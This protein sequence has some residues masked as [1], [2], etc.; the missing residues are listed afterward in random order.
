M[1]S[2]TINNVKNNKS[3]NIFKYK[4]Y[5]NENIYNITVLKEN[6]IE[7][8]TIT[9]NWDYNMVL[10][11]IKITLNRNVITNNGKE[12]TIMYHYYT[13]IVYS[14]YAGIRNECKNTNH[15]FYNI[16]RDLSLQAINKGKMYT[17]NDYALKMYL[18]LYKSLL[19]ND[20]ISIFNKLEPFYNLEYCFACHKDI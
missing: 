16:D 8:N 5:N 1:S 4:E 10:K 18:F 7:G 20:D 14:S 19:N 3:S 17:D 6:R 13:L 11:L 12:I 15:D 9:T 2:L